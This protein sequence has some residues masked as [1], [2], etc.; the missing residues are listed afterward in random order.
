M[1]RGTFGQV[2]KC[3]I[4]A[5][6]ELVAVK[7][8]KR[9]PSFHNQSVQE[10]NTLTKLNGMDKNKFL[11]LRDSFFF[12]GHN[13]AVLELLSI[14]LYK[15]TASVSQR[16]AFKMDQI[17]S[18]GTQILETLSILKRLNIIHADLKPDNILFKSSDDLYSVKLIDYGSAL[19]GNARLLYPVQTASYRAPEVILGLH[20]S[21]AIDM[22]SFG[23]LIAEMLLGKS[24]FPTENEAALLHM[25]VDLLKHL[26][27]DNMIFTSRLGAHYFFTQNGTKASKTRLKPMKKAGHD[28]PLNRKSLEQRIMGLVSDDP[29][30]SA[31]DKIIHKQLLDFLQKILVFD[32]SQRLT[33]DDA[34]KHPFITSAAINNTALSPDG[35]FTNALHSSIKESGSLNEQSRE[36]NIRLTEESGISSIS[37]TSTTIA[38]SNRTIDTPATEIQ[39]EV[40]SGQLALSTKQP[41][42]IL[43]SKPSNREL[44]SNSVKFDKSKDET[45][46]FDDHIS[47][48]SKDRPQSAM[49]L[50]SDY[51]AVNYFYQQPRPKTAAPTLVNYNI[52]NMALFNEYHSPTVYMA[53]KHEVIS[54]YHRYPLIRP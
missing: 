10:I 40:T 3:R 30:C 44:S 15:Y 32:P 14:S 53:P 16:P 9:E 22:W 36:S 48:Y 52:Q 39:E 6:G 25:M 43:K 54:Q 21:T 45:I 47:T 37:T 27:P 4:K 24:L 31:Q 41:K 26:P 8:T 33:P 19:D 17:Q 35:I 5:T 2:V 11:Q 23:C 29:T 28:I 12:R 50:T 34:L 49:P 42:S 46:L 1:G 7:V 20:Y 18:I 38:D 51:K 13:C